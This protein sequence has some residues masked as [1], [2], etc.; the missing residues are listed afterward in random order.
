M[1]LISLCMI[2]K[3][4]AELLPRALGNLDG[5]WDELIVVDT[6]S[7]DNTVEVAE[8][9]GATVICYEMPPPG[10]LGAARNVALDEATGKWIVMLDADEII[11]NPRGVRDFLSRTESDN[12]TIVTS[13]FHNYDATG[14]VELAWWQP[15]IWKNGL[16]HYE[17]RA[18]EVPMWCGDGDQRMVGLDAIFE[19]RPPIA[20]NGLKNG[21][22]LAML[23]A[24]VN[25]RPNDVHPAYFLSRQYALVEKWEDCIRLSL[26]YLDLNNGVDNHDAFGT[27]A[28]AYTQTGNH[29]QAINVLHDAMAAQ[30]HRRIWWIRLAEM[31]MAAA[32]WN[33]ALAYLRGA[34]ELLPV[35]E[36]TTE[37]KNVG[38]GLYALIDKC[39]SA[40]A[41]MEAING[42][43]NS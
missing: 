35:F 43:A 13:R 6:G 32:Q 12:S 30:P 27:L 42:N 15:R 1:T 31:Y 8:S 37:V 26:H 20:R 3:N 21:L 22:L 11:S 41:N 18:H 40:L 17:H 29:A 14:A 16:Y 4:E 7:T 28:T 23:E 33:I 9:L 38:A 5:F 19:H 2:V 36:W 24:D 25:E 39:Q 10:H 34:S